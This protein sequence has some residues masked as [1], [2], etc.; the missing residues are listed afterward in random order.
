MFQIQEPQRIMNPFFSIVISL[1]NKEKYIKSTIES[2]LSQTF[3]DFEMII[4][5][6]GSTDD[7]ETIVRHIHDHR[8]KYFTQE[9]KGA[10]AGRNTAISKSS[11]MYI[12]LLDA[13]DLWR[14]TYLETIHQLIQSHPDQHVFAT[15]VTR[16]TSSNAI[17]S[18]YSI[19][20]LKNKGVYL[21]DYFESSYI[22]TLLTSSSTVVHH[23]VF[24]K[25]GTYD[26]SIK[27][28]QDIDLW[29]RIG[30]HY[31]VIFINETLVRYRYEKRSL[32]NR[33]IQV[34][35]KPK[36]DKHIVLEAT[37]TG[38]NKFIDLNR[39]SM[40]IL[41]KL[42]NDQSSF[43][44]YEKAIND[45]NLNRRQR[46]LLKQPAIIVQLLHAIKKLMQQLGIQLSAF[47]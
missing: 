37:N 30:L 44:R 12:A 14:P 21:V 23:K 33:T 4:V 11:G 9:N 3:Q 27:S 47:K 36:F 46:F 34:M 13:D 38:L 45:T 40:A 10:S 5:N 29:I 43:D 20:D 25:I 41:S 17:P 24:E 15:A 42:G 39:Y 35:D 26:T 22:N 1:Y 16:E 28:G 6:D 18:V 8:I 2:V 7:S 32:S 31:K 19:K